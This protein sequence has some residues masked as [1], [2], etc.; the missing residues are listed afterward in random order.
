MSFGDSND[1]YF[2]EL[3]IGNNYSLEGVVAFCSRG[4][5][6]SR[7]FEAI[8]RN[9][10]GRRDNWDLVASHELNI[11]DAQNA[12]T[13]KAV[14]LDPAWI[15]YVEEDMLPEPGTLSRMLSAGSDVVTVD[16]KLENG[17][18]AI[19]KSDDGFF[20]GGMG[21]LLV[22][23]LIFDKIKKP[24]FDTLAFN[25]MGGSLP[26]RLRY[27]GQDVFFYHRLAEAGIPVKVIE[28]TIHHLRVV[29]RGDP[30]QNDGAHEIVKL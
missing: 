26:F 21:C 2:K 16:Y 11:P 19:S 30:G 20:Y 4:L 17:T 9:L 24:W 15:W 29:R 10:K 23:R 28:S 8:W 5:M 22:R 14:A 3:K 13:E 25:G 27:G 18:K 7:T 1:E 6:H 12:V